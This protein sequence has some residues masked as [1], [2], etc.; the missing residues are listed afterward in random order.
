MAAGHGRAVD[1]AAPVEAIRRG[2]GR[3]FGTVIGSMLIGGSSTGWC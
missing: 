2:F 1:I 3:I